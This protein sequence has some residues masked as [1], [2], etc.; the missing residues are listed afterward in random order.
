MWLKLYKGPG[1]NDALAL[2]VGPRGSNIYVT[3]TGSTVGYNAATGTQ[4]WVKPYK[5]GAPSVAVNPVTSTVYVTGESIGPSR[6]ED[7][8]TIAYSG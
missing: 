6:S 7:Y 4:L 3:G 5:G 1:P 2:A 8:L